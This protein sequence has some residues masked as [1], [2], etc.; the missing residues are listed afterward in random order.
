[1]SL[2][3]ASYY[4]GTMPSSNAPVSSIYKSPSSASTTNYGVVL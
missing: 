3:S 2:Q 1:M 4:K